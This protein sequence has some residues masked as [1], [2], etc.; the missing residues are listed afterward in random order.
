MAIRIGV[1]GL[2]K[3][4]HDQHL[5]TLLASPDFELICSA[6]LQ[7]DSP[8]GATY[9]S[10]E[11]MLEAE[12]SIQAVAMCQ[13]PQARFEAARA[14]LDAG[15]HVLLEKPPGATLAEVKALLDRARAK[16]LTLFASW[17]SRHAPAVEPARA[18]LKGKHIRSAAIIWKEDARVWH[19]GQAWI[20]QPGGLGVFD[21]GINALSIATRI[22]P[23]FFLREGTLAFPSNCGAPIAAN[24]AFETVEGSPIEAEFDF[25]QTGPQIWDIRVETDEGLLL[26]SRGG[27]ALSIDGAPQT[28]EPEA[29]YRGVYRRFAEL[30]AAGE[31]DVD[32]G[33]LRHVADAFLRAAREEAEPFHDEPAPNS[34]S[35]AG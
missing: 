26:L 5:P 2:G 12:P 33:P 8:K 3:I 25:R 10:V 35:I 18:W 11:A 15:K 1:V 34:L 31:C 28:L 32:R 21:P 30:I 20:W 22:L 17:H 23:P 19:P 24:L 4:A 7:G 9:R 16:G 29:E 14:A 13:P 6:S 27:A